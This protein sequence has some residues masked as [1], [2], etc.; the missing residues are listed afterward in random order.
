ML[1]EFDDEKG[2]DR[3]VVVALHEVLQQDIL[4]KAGLLL[5]CKVHLKKSADAFKFIKIGS[6]I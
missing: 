5:N 4:E 6:N 3:Q 2:L 1:G